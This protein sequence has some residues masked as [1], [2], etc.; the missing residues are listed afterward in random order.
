[1]CGI[2]GIHRRSDKPF[3][4]MG[5]FA[6]ELLLGIET[7]GMDSTGFL[8]LKDSGKVQVEKVPVTARRFVKSRMRFDADARTVLLHT[9]FATR[10]KVNKLNAHPQISGR[11]AA[12]HNG[13]IY[14]ADELFDTF[15]ITR[16]AQVDSEIIPALIDHA[17]WDE[18][19]AALELMTGGAATAV[20]NVE[21]PR[22]VLL[23]RT[24]TYPLIYLAT[25]D[26]V[27]WASTEQTIVQAFRFAYGKT[28]PKGEWGSLG[29]WSLMRVNGVID[30]SRLDPVTPPKPPA[31]RVK[32][33]AKG[34]ARKAR[35]AKAAKKGTE[36]RSPG[37]KGRGVG[38][39]TPRAPQPVRELLGLDAVRDVMAWTGMTYAE[40]FDAV[41]GV[42]D[43]D[44]LDGW[45]DRLWRDLDDDLSRRL[46]AERG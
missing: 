22:E 10:G 25:E 34:K 40:A 23:A 1:M 37:T 6:D 3:P 15:G 28:P 9:R 21:H 38:R 45:S 36:K 12:I 27:V 41:Y 32:T 17:G 35:K 18:A 44:S 7:R 20:V 8:A 33:S 39:N 4:K 14:N 31:P 5:R 2:A 30:L 26:F 11:C 29:P 16:R 24:Q 46:S 13:T 19:G 42:T 43:E